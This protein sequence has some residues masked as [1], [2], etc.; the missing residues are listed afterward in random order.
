M[1]HQAVDTTLQGLIFQTHLEMLRTQQQ[2][3]SLIELAL[4]SQATR[5]ERA[6][7]TLQVPF[8]FTKGDRN[9]CLTRKRQF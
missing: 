1:P 9:S 7:R 8:V 2:D 5:K 6:E 3:S 4:T